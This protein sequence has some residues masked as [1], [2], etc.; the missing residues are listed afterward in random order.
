MTKTTS[1]SD[2]LFQFELGFDLFISS[3]NVFTVTLIVS[4][5]QRIASDRS[6]HW[7]RVGAAG[8]AGAC[9]HKLNANSS[10][11]VSEKQAERA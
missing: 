11:G 4:V 9:D 5:L 3:T 6:H 10:S 1:F 7:E 2:T 8:A